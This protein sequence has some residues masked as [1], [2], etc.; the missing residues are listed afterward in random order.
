MHL[1]ADRCG[2]TGG[3][4]AAGALPGSPCTAP[5]PVGTQ[6]AALPA[7]FSALEAEK[8]GAEKSISA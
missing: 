4:P 5:G 6:G 3:E 8:A 1:H 7:P 2:Q